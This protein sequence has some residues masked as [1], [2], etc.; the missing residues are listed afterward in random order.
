MSA[1]DNGQ[2]LSTYNFQSDGFHNGNSQIPTGMVQSLNP[3]QVLGIAQSLNPPG[4][5]GGLCNQTVRGGV[6]WMR[7]LAFRYRK[8]KDTY[9]NYRNR[10]AIFYDNFNLKNGSFKIKYFTITLTLILTILF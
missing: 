3:A 10:Y 8:I 6:D 2:D 5:Q 1:D 4:S 7:K 9:N